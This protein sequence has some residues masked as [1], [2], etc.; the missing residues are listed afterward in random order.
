MADQPRSQKRISE[1]YQG[2]L[3]RYTRGTPFRRLKLFCFLLA[4]FASIGAVF[5]FRYWGS[6]DFVKYRDPF[7]KITSALPA[8]SATQMWSPI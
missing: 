4:V 6:Q 5:G 1:S 7:L 2:H 8:R 3:D